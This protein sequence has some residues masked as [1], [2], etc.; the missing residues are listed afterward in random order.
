MKD[1]KVNKD[2]CGPYWA[3]K[4]VNCILSKPFRASCKVHDLDYESKKYTRKEADARF[5]K[6][7]MK[8]ASKKPLAPMWKVLGYLYYLAVL[9]GGQKSW[10][11]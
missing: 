2:Y 10:E 9:V 6:N 1:K 7:L 11:Q 4:W 3:P 5:L 8:Q